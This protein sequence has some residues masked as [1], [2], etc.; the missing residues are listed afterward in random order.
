MTKNIFYLIILY[1]Y[2]DTVHNKYFY[3]S[4][5]G[6]VRLDAD[7]TERASSTSLGCNQWRNMR[8]I[9]K[10]VTSQQNNVNIFYSL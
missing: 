6:Q 8:L 10:K 3:F 9:E 2:M 1:C 4:E 5:A 7:E